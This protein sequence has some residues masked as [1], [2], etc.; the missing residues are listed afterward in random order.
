MVD[1]RWYKGKNLV[2]VIKKA[3]GKYLVQA[4]EMCKA[5]NK[6]IGYLLGSYNNLLD[7]HTYLR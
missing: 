4:I 5:G 2:E 1:Y 7:Y 3:K 6:E